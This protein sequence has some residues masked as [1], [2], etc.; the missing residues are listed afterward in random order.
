[1]IE[2]LEL[3]KLRAKHPGLFE[4]DDPAEGL[5]AVE[6]LLLEH[7]AMATALKK[8][9]KSYIMKAARSPALHM[10][11]E[12]KREAYTAEVMA[13]AADIHR[14]SSVAASNSTG[15][16]ATQEETEELLADMAEFMKTRNKE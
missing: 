7:E 4:H 6:K 1:M 16:V 13:R 10:V 5:M 15:R 8:L 14:N 12:A 3:A 2:T 11:R 9:R